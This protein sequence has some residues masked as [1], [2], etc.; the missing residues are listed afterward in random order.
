MN[1]RKKTSK[2]T[3]CLAIDAA[4]AVM[5]SKIRDREREKKTNP[6]MDDAAVAA[7]TAAVGA[8]SLK[9]EEPE[10]AE[11]T[12]MSPRIENASVAAIAAEAAARESSSG[13]ITNAARFIRLFAAYFQLYES[14]FFFLSFSNKFSR[15]HR[16]FPSQL[17]KLP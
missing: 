10:T 13:I 16:N 9:D 7:A 11:K 1:S 15:F 2:E 5:A 12:R 8:S 14:I 6:R 17:L 3:S 4:D